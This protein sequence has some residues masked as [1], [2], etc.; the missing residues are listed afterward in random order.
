MEE[1]HKLR[2]Q[3]SNIVA[4]NF[5]GT[6]AGFIPNLPPPKDK[7]VRVVVLFPALVIM[8]II[9]HR[10]LKVLRQLFASGFIDQ[11]AVRK[12]LVSQDGA[13]LKHT[14][15]KNVPYRALGV[16]E[17]VFIHPSSVLSNTAP[18]DYI[19]FHE[20]VRTS[21]TWI[22]GLTVVN[23]A[24]LASLGAKTGLC[25]FSKSFK[26]RTGEELVLPRFGPEGWE[27]PAFKAG[28]VQ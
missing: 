23:P 8:L 7:Q 12:D 19:V 13:G 27:L 25:T 9:T 2:A 10:Q 24:W 22:K 18:P 28:S 4:V 5:P 20:L 21:R 6:D 14:T 16:S 1:I 15:S 3:I 11:V 17:D 26:N